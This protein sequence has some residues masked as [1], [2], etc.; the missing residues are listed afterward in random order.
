M[1]LVS[2][3]T[4]ILYPEHYIDFK[5]ISEFEKK[6]LLEIAKRKISDTT[7]TLNTK[8]NVIKTIIGYDNKFLEHYK[9]LPIQY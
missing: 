8:W 1:F 2:L 3:S 9:T 5:Q 4:L 6:L 7:E